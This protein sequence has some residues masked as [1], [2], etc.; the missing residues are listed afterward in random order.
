[1]WGQELP[2][3]PRSQLA[4]TSIR[5][6]SEKRPETGLFISENTL[7]WLLGLTTKALSRR[8]GLLLKQG[9]C[10]DQIDG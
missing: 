3:V 1:M 6:M 5:E 4:V 2:L 7:L 10:D 9:I 8:P